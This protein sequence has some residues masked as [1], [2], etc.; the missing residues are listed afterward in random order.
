ML[1]LLCGVLTREESMTGDL[2]CISSVSMIQLFS[3]FNLDGHELHCAWWELCPTM[4]A[5]TSSK[6]SGGGQHVAMCLE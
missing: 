5:D 4:D 6:S 3:L 1:V 2:C